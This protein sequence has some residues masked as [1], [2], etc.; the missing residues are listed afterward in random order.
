MFEDILC[1]C[2]RKN[3]TNP[4]PALFLVQKCHKRMRKKNPPSQ[5]L[6]DLHP[7]KVD[8]LANLL[9]LTVHLSIKF[10]KIGY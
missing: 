3:N 9:P 6:A 2:I 8:I 7:L 4:T 1:M 10:K 5:K